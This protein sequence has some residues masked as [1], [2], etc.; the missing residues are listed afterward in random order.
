[1]TLYYVVR[2]EKGC[3]CKGQAVEGY[4]RPIDAQNS[5]AE[6]EA[7][8]PQ[9]EYDVRPKITDDEVPFAFGGYEG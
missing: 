7:R 8:N 6:L 1:M 2:R 5:C 9:Y 4:K 3:S